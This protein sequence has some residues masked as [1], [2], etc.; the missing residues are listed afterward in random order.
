MITAVRVYIKSPARQG[1]PATRWWDVVWG[2]KGTQTSQAN[3]L[4]SQEWDLYPRQGGFMLPNAE[5]LLC[6]SMRDM[7]GAGISVGGDLSSQ[8]TLDH[9]WGYLCLLQL[10]GG[11]WNEGW[12][13]RGCST[14]HSA[15]KDAP[16]P[17]K[18]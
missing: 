13:Q 15:Q 7:L 3:L 4:G 1:V 10:A 2:E 9:V 11:S 12:G 18:E 16:H 5:S 6:L 14:P 17:S 8:G